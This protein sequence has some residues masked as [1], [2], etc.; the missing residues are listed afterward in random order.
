MNVFVG[1]GKTLRS[2]RT[3]NSLLEL[4]CD[5]CDAPHLPRMTGSK[6]GFHERVIITIAFS[7]HAHLYL[8]FLEHGEIALARILSSLDR[9]DAADQLLAFAACSPFLALLSSI[10][11]LARGEW[12]IPPPSARRYP[13]GLPNTTI[14]SRVPIPVISAT[15][16]VLAA[17][18]LNFRLSRLGATGLSC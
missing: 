7:T 11:R 6:E 16:L 14:R 10:A 3:Q 12:P 13:Q 18:A 15:H 4:V 9:S 1:D 2:I 17:S 8:S 5:S